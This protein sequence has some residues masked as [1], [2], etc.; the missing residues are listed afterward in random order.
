MVEFQK[1]EESRILGIRVRRSR[2][3]SFVGANLGRA[4]YVIQVDAPS[5][6]FFAFTR[7]YENQEALVVCNF[8]ADDLE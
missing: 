3:T 4:W 8:T 6:E 5:E 7:Q 2:G 1:D